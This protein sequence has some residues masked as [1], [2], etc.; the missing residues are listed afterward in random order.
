[1]LVPTCIFI[2]KEGKCQQKLT[3]LYICYSDQFHEACAS[4]QINKATVD[5][6]EHRFKVSVFYHQ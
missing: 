2:Q 4:M 1:M 3:Y 5:M 6:M